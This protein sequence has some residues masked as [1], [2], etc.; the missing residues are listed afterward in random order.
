MKSPKKVIILGA[1][2]DLGSAVSRVFY[3]K[4]YRLSL[5]ASKFENLSELKL[6]LGG[7]AEVYGYDFTDKNYEAQISNDWI[8]HSDADVLVIC[9]GYY[10]SKFNHLRPTS[11]IDKY[12]HVNCF[13]PAQVMKI[14]AKTAVTDQKARRVVYVTSTSKLAPTPTVYASAKTA[15]TTMAKL[16]FNEHKNSPVGFV[17]VIPSLIHSKALNTLN[18]TQPTGMVMFSCKTASSN[19]PAAMTC[20]WGKSS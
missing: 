12:F 5:W 4:G 1:S 19:Y 16:V 17:E 11:E 10:D 9:T 6:E 8:H 3:Q 20:S 13:G 2:G 15:L 18:S 7:A 14:F